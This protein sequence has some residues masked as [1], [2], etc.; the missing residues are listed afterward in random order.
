[1]RAHASFGLAAFF[2]AFRMASRAGRLRPAIDTV[3]IA[4]ALCLAVAIRAPG[5]TAAASGALPATERTHSEA[6]ASS[7]VLIG[8]ADLRNFGVEI[9]PANYERG[10]DHY[11]R[12]MN[13]P[14]T[15]TAARRAYHDRLIDQLLVERYALRNQKD[16]DPEFRRR[17]SE[18]RRRLLFEFII[19]REVLGRVAV[20]TDSVAAYYEACRTDFTEPEK[21]QVRHILTDAREK[22]EQVR[23]RLVDGADFA[24]L[25]GEVSIHPSARQGGVLPPFSRGTYQAPFEQA[26]F[27]LK[28]GE[29]SPVVETE[30]GFHVIEKTAEVPARIKPLEEVAEQVRR[31]VEEQ[32]RK[33]VLTAFLQ[34]LRR[35]AG[36]GQPDVEKGQ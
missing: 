20:T 35:E 12:E 33:K 26:A 22:A 3:R 19:E 4:T 21:V 28:V 7:G 5:D 27:A 23:A 25:A 31:L 11:L 29:L 34:A 30:L 10:L 2:R 16:R 14:A 6:P 17:L 36:T 8:P 15:D 32:E 13:A 18:A 9:D 1:M 24:K